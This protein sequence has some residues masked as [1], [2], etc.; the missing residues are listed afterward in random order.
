MPTT[1]PHC[2]F[3]LAD[4]PDLAGQFVACPHCGHQFPLAPP[5]APPT[6]TDPPQRDPGFIPPIININHRRESQPQHSSHS[7]G[8]ASLVIGVV[9]IG[10]LSL[11]FF[12][13]IS[14]NEVG[15]VILA[16]SAVIGAFGVLL[17][18]FAALVSLA[19]KGSG[20]GFALGGM[21]LGGIPVAIAVIVTWSTMDAL[22][23]ARRDRE[24]RE[25]RGTFSE[26]DS[27]RGSND[28]R[29]FMA[30]PR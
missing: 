12:A 1:C 10:V 27:H 18:L 22:E 23:R 7:V 17:G 29:E 6:I 11:V 4:A 13:P 16:A 21:F 9:A 3:P 14:T 2:S 5:D 8:I 19:R 25:S 15:P 28:L 30:G 24:N 26:G 20:I